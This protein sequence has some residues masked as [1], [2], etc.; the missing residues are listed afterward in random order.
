[1]TFIPNVLSEVDTNNTT[2]TTLTTSAVFT[3]ISTNTTGYNTIQ[4]S[5]TS[6]ADSGPLGLQIQFSPDNSTWTT[7][8]YETYF[9]PAL[10]DKKYSIKNKYYRIIYTNDGTA[11]TNFSLISRL[12]NETP[13]PNAISVNVFD[14]STEH[15]YDAFGKLRVSNPNTLL[16]LRF[17]GQTSGN[18]DFY[19]NNLQ[20]DKQF[21][22]IT[23]TY[24]NSKLVMSG[25]AATPGSYYISQ[26]RNYCVYQPGKSLLF[27]S[28]AVINPGDTGFTNKLGYYDNDIPTGGPITTPISVKNG[29][30]FEHNGTTCFVGLKNDTETLVPQSSWNIDKMDGTGTSKINLDFSKTQLFVIDM[31]WLGVGRVRYGF[32][33]FGQIVYCHQI[34]NINTLTAPYT[35]NINLPV[36][37]T[38]QGLTGSG[39]GNFTQIC[40]TVISEGGYNPVGRPFSASSGGITASANTETPILA[41]RASGAVGTNYKHQSIIPTSLSGFDQSNTNVDLLRLRLYLAPDSPSSNTSTSWTQV[42]ASY[43]IVEYSAGTSIVGSGTFTTNNSI[44]LSESYFSGKNNIALSQSLENIFSNLITQITSNILN[45]SDILLITI[46]PS[47]ASTCYAEI[48]WNEVY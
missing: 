21:S 10:F 3:G 22:G 27:M 37:F 11:Q 47:S 7:F 31:E 4:I 6:N 5:I 39:T 12:S 19:S 40:S 30:F 42:N 8:Y 34:T 1:M 18:Y 14:N 46:Q 20:I 35:N 17:P 44:I 38:M 36:C 26:S 16:D 48:D 29:L 15:M 24:G 28:S 33:A 41:I 25:A 45:K 13:D 9:S 2:S 43:S 23:G 32:Y